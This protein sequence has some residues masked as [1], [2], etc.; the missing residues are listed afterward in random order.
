MLKTIAAIIVLAVAAV[1]ILAA[2]KPDMLRVERKA[3]MQATPD[4]IFPLINDFHNWPSWSPYEKLDPQMRRTLSGAPNGEGTVY[5]WA[6]ERRRSAKDAWK[7]PTPR[8]R[9]ASR[10]SSISSNRSKAITL[11][12]SCSRPKAATSPK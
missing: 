11:P 4:K 5:E 6:G 8:H 9:L 2:T 12:S 7:S 1:V 3:S 10:S